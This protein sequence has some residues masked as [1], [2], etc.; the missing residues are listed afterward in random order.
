MTVL[1]NQPGFD[2]AKVRALPE[3]AALTEFPVVFGFA[4]KCCP[5][6]STGFPPT[7]DQMARTIERPVMFQGR[8]FNPDRVDEIMVTPQFAASSASMS[9]TR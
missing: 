9:A 7:D 2:W 1:P 5:D 6:A 3:V 4:L 8:M